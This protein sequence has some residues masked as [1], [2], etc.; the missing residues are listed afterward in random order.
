MRSVYEDPEYTDV[1]QELKAE[2]QRLQQHYRVPD[3][4]GSVPKDPSVLQGRRVN[5][6]PR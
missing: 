2:L 6:R 1:V 4:R 3:D 5:R